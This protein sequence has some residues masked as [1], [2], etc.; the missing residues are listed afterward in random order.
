MAVVTREE[1][2]TIQV[3]MC[4]QVLDRNSNNSIVLGVMRRKCRYL[5]SCFCEI[6]IF[7]LLTLE[8]LFDNML[9]KGLW[10][11]SLKFSSQFLAQVELADLHRISNP[12]MVETQ[13]NRNE[14]DMILAVI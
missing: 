11:F 13:W 9:Q 8:T 14:T 3:M 6:Y 2:K 12:V 5:K 7:F 10:E 4:Y 1:A